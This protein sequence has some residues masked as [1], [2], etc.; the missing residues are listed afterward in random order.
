M[1]HL[2]EGR[3]SI[4]RVDGRRLIAWIMVVVSALMLTFF[5]GALAGRATA[6]PVP[7]PT[8]LDTM[9]RFYHCG[10]WFHGHTA[11]GYLLLE[12]HLPPVYAHVGYVP[13]VETLLMWN[14]R[15]IHAVPCQK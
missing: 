6:A 2:L 1:I 9:S 12:K 5:A 11:R 4:R 13:P 3:Y 7:D 10:E 14:R 15:G 8:N